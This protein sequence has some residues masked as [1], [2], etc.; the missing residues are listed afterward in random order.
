[1][2]D[3]KKPDIETLAQQL[4]ELGEDPESILSNAYH[5][6]K[7]FQRYKGAPPEELL[8]INPGAIYLPSVQDAIIAAAAPLGWAR[9]IQEEGYV[10]GEH[11]MKLRGIEMQACQDERLFLDRVNQALT[12]K[13][14]RNSKMKTV[15]GWRKTALK[16]YE[17][18][19]SRKT[20]LEA[21][22]PIVAAQKEDP[23]FEYKPPSGGKTAEAVEY[24]I[25]DNRTIARTLDL[26]FPT[27]S[28]WKN[29]K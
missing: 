18:R 5:A 26:D 16:V 9:L 17:L 19:L 1:M 11:P 4:R 24:G 6:A 15:L 29:R 27:Y 20:T 12:S 2:E 28:E 21:A 3:D 7:Q 8:K 13:H 25:R 23:L 10:F 14:S 22:A